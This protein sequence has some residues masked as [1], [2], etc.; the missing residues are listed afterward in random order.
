MARTVID[1]DEERLAEA[2]QILGTRTK[3]ATVNA[4]SIGSSCS[5]MR[6][7]PSDAL[8]LLDWNNSATWF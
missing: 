4:G 6:A 8:A 3:V 5:S 2:A 1:L 7:T